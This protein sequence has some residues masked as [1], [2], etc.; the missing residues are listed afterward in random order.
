MSKAIHIFEKYQKKQ[1]VLRGGQTA[2]LTEKKESSF[3][4]GA[5]LTFCYFFDT[6]L[7][8]AKKL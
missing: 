4:K 1:E 5:F 3:F 8:M 7:S 6:L 2:K